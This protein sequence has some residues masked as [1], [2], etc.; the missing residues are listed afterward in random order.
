MKWNIRGGRPRCTQRLG[1]S[2]RLGRVRELMCTTQ[3]K[4]HGGAVEKRMLLGGSHA[5]MEVL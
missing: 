5:S 4:E 1:R 3:K 2:L